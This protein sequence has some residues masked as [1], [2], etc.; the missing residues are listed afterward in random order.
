MMPG[1]DGYEVAAKIKRNVDTENI[2]VILAHR[3]ERSQVQDVAGATGAGAEELSAKPVDRA[4]LCVRVRKLCCASKHTGIISTSTARVLESK[5][6]S[7]IA[8]LVESL[9]IT[10]IHIRRGTGRDRACGARRAVVAGQSAPSASYWDTS[11]RSC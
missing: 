6:D 2:P 3:S 5:V 4:E 7:G 8:E 11:T 10:T 9:S 1:L